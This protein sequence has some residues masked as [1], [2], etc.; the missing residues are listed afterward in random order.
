MTRKTV[1]LDLLST[2]Q[3]TNAQI[4][5]VLELMPYEVASLMSKMRHRGLVNR[6]LGKR[7]RAT[8]TLVSS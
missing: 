1:I 7:R 3:K 4:A 5:E 8:Y 2:G 6:T